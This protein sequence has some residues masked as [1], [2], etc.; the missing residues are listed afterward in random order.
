MRVLSLIGILIFSVVGRAACPVLIGNYDCPGL[1]TIPAFKLKISQTPGQ[2]FM[3]YDVVMTGGYEG[4][5]STKAST[6]GI[7]NEDGA[8][9]ACKSE[10]VTVKT[11]VVPVGDIEGQVYLGEKNTVRVTLIG[12]TP[13]PWEALICKKL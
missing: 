13:E 11:N 10:R 12:A 7:K 5:A 1:L 8:F 3:Q 6:E 9:S 2:G 4:K